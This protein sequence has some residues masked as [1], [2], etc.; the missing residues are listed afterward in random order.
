M[1][2][3]AS[4]KFLYKVPPPWNLVAISCLSKL[5]DTNIVDDKGQGVSL[6]GSRQGG[7]YPFAIL[8]GRLLFLNPRIPLLQH[9]PW[10]LRLPHRHSKVLN[11][12][13]L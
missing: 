4:L 10:F 9:L 13:E 6:R 12:G 5:E 1:P 7:D 3:Q 2:R 8:H 11:E